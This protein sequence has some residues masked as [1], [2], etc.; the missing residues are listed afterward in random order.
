MRDLKQEA[1]ELRA[2][3]MPPWGESRAGTYVGGGEFE[4]AGRFSEMGILNARLRSCCCAPIT[5][6]A[7][8]EN[9]A[10]IIDMRH[11]GGIYG[12]ILNTK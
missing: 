6:V 11:G 8:G 2:R 3:G 9:H 10:R 5:E 4:L 12:E 1:G 7:I